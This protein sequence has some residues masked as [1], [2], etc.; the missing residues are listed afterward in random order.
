MILY[1]TRRIMKSLRKVIGMMLALSI[2]LSSM[3]AF[4][5]AKFSDVEAGSVVETA[6]VK[7]VDKGIISGY[8]DGTFKPEGAITRAEFAA[9]ITR[10]KGIADSAPAGAVTGFADLD[11]DAGAAW[12]KPYVKAAVDAGI[13][14][15]FNDGT[16]RAGESV[17]YEQAIKMIICAL[18]YQ[19]LADEE[20]AKIE[21]ASWSAGYIAVANQKGITKDAEATDVTSPATRGVVAILTD[22]ALEDSAPAVDY[23]MSAAEV[24]A[25]RAGIRE[26][27][28]LRVLA[29]GNS[30]TDDTLEYL[31]EI[32]AADGIA[33]YA[34]NMYKG[35][36]SIKQHWERMNGVDVYTRK[37]KMP[38]NTNK[39]TENSSFADCIATDGG[40]WDYVTLHQRSSYAPYFERFWTEE[41]PY[42]TDIASHVREVCPDAEF[43][44]H[45]CWT[46]YTDKIE[47]DYE[48]YKPIVEGLQKEQYFT[49]VFEA[50]KANYLKAAETVGNPNR[51]IPANEA[52]HLAVTK[53]GIAEY[54]DNAN[55]S[56]ES[57]KPEARALFMDGSAHLTYDYG[58]VLAA[59]TWYE[60]LTGMDVRQNTYK[61]PN[62]PEADMALLREI[63]HEACSLPEYNPAN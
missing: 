59:L 15:G 18:G 9:V 31:S 56:D 27:K 28:E 13:I 47:K 38:D 32:G 57:Y 39:K 4:A 20:L 54:E 35:G 48:T 53:Y 3:V 45:G 26:R 42:I 55:T 22:N 34:V 51:V 44:M 8:P 25:K 61:H 46:V 10:F 63:A 2:A 52:L 7:L 29:I 16:F 14:N 24:E 30:H 50:A 23:A 17:T 43:L 6:V 12:A 60:Y 36:A 37:E 21:N 49:A 58:R 19:A 33:V 62:V 40:K 1:H 5:E 41:A 11:A